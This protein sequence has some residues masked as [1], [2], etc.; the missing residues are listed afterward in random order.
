MQRAYLHDGNHRQCL[1]TQLNVFED[2]AELQDPATDLFCSSCDVKAFDKVQH[3]VV[4]ECCR[5]LGMPALFV[6]YVVRM[7]RDAVR[8]VRTA[9]GL[10]PPFPLLSSV[11]QG[12]ALA[13]LLYIITRNFMISALRSNPLVASRPSGYV[14]ANGTEVIATAYADDVNVYAGLWRDILVQHYWCSSWSS[15]TF[16][17]MHVDQK[18]SLCWVGSGVG[19][20]NGTSGDAHGNRGL[21]CNNG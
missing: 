15:S 13:A 16:G 8:A 4:E 7:L 19:V 17:E 10:S 14:M 5:A 21:T 1:H 20:S 9:H 18:K 12:D 11:H 6:R 3:F 2:F